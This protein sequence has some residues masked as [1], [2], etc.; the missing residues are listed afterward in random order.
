MDKNLHDLDEVIEMIKS[1][2]LLALTGDEKVLSKLP[3]GN[4]IGA[5]TPYFVDNDRGLFTVDRIYVN[6]LYAIN[7]DYKFASYDSSNI[8]TI[9][10]N[11]FENGYTILFIPAFQ[12]IHSKYA[13][14]ASDID[15]IYDNAIGGMVAGADLD[16]FTA[17]KVYQGFEA[18]EFID[19]AV[20]VHVKLPEDKTSRI[21]ILN[22]FQ[23]DEDSVE[24]RFLAD[25]FE[26]TSCL[27]DG[28]KVNFAK[29]I[30][31]KGIDIETP[32][33]SNNS[34]AI[35]N[36]CFKEL[37]EETNT[38]SFYGPVFT[39]TVYKFSLPID[40]YIG[41]FNEKIESMTQQYQ[42]SCNCILNYLYGNLRDAE[43]KLFGG[44]VVFGEI[45][46]NL[47]NQTLTNLVI[48]ER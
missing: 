23:Q 38:V 11:G 46:Y 48:D 25:G 29:Y 47:L 9:A 37:N 40:N 36:V 35:I 19:Q 1:G 32:M 2:K 26:C 14:I 27:I 43:T 34:G 42:F 18:R 16:N 12:E 21:E 6:E 28:E 4:W 45:G 24:I 15:G 39:D 31:E 17:P 5:T 7:E 8:A 33:S 22:I 10:K 3:K 30:K 44:P 20:A 13:L 41:R